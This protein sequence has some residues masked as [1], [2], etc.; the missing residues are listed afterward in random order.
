MGPITIHNRY[1]RKVMRN[2][3]TQIL[4]ATALSSMF[5]QTI[6]AQSDEQIVAETLLGEAR[7]EGRVGLYA[8][9]CVIQERINDKRWPST[10]RKVCLQPKQFSCWNGRAIKCSLAGNKKIKHREY[11]LSLARVI[12]AKKK[13]KDITDKANHYHAVGVHPRWARGIKP[14]VVLGRHIFYRL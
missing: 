12:V 11:A 10:G 5:A 9:A 6:N 14:V 4:F 8:V 7:G 1:S 13:L 2:L 3:C